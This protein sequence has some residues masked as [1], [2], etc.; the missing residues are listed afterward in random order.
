MIADDPVAQAHPKG[1]I[2]VLVVDDQADIRRS[3]EKELQRA[4][5]SVETAEDCNSA[6]KCV[7]QHPFH[8]A[9]V[10]LHMPGF[11]GKR[12]R[13]AGMD[14][15]KRLK[16]TNPEIATIVLTGEA[17]IETAKEAIRLGAIDY[18]EKGLSAKGLGGKVIQLL[19][20]DLKAK[21]VEASGV[22]FDLK[23]NLG[24]ATSLIRSE[25]EEVFR[26][27]FF[28]A[29]EIN[30]VEIA[31]GTRSAGVYRVDARDPKGWRAPV[32]AKIDWKDAVTAT[33]ANYEE[34]VM[35]RVS[36]FRYAKIEKVAFST[37]RAGIIMTIVD[38]QVK[39]LADLRRYFRMS[40]AADVVDA[41]N[42]LFG[43]TLRY[44]H[45]HRAE[46]SMFLLREYHDYLEWDMARLE[47]AFRRFLADYYDVEDIVLE[48]AEVSFKN[49]L[50]RL[51]GIENGY[52]SYIAQTYK[53]I[54]HG[55]LNVTN[56]LVDKRQNCWLIDFT[57]TGSSHIFRDFVEL[58][59]SLKFDAQ[60]SENLRDLCRLEAA[61]MAQR[62]LDEEVSLPDGDA[63]TQKG[64]EA[65]QA[66]R[67][68]AS[69][70]YGPAMSNM[71]EFYLGLLYYT[72]NML[73]FVE[74]Q[75]SKTKKKCIL[76]SAS[77][78]CDAL[79]TMI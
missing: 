16:K 53:V 10:D 59:T 57:S 24:P 75:V 65:V 47:K 3:L 69:H 76:Y 30:V 34:Y 72:L 7:A 31:R 45:S 4:G 37:K 50:H 35:G 29:L 62:R 39:E 25:D 27:L 48:E 6:M 28:D 38:T 46:A 70:A 14:L 74:S 33:K 68:Y 15:I 54:S 56:I 44:W 60:D 22:N 64:F 36:D 12:S 42:G 18:L 63:S 40:P 58:E 11:D 19:P 51:D 77:L 8:I 2:C 1:T 13:T 41:L 43:N 20:N 67:R 32:V 26:R 21:L 9:I 5:F 79:E 52:R 78:I 61:L 17:T 23:I 55:D 66:L 71:T 73:R 49:P